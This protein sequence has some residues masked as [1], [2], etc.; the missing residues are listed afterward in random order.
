MLLP[1]TAAQSTS[2]AANAEQEVRLVIREIESSL[3]AHDRSKLDQ[4]MAADFALLHSTGQLESRQSFLDRAAAGSL[5]S[6]RAPAE[7]LEES[8]RVYDSRTALRTTRIKASLHPSDR[9][10]LE[11]SLRTIDVY[12]EVSGRWVWVSEQSTPL[13]AEPP[14]TR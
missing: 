4:L 14:P 5:M 2:P 8:I 7:L 13:P 11:I 12:V 1:V 10:P 9:A 6:Q 3:Q